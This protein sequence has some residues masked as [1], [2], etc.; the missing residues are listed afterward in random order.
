MD[1]H[2]WR[3]P[4]RDRIDLRCYLSVGTRGRVYLSDESLW[5]ERRQAT[6]QSRPAGRRFQ[7]GRAFVQRRTGKISGKHQGRAQ[8]TITARTHE[9][10]EVL[11]VHIPAMANRK[12][13]LVALENLRPV[14]LPSNSGW[15][16]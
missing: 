10:A 6:H 9:A 7:P 8:Y 14:L 4:R 11:E 2:G 13:T 3:I 12:T 5:V 15:N 1:G 16:T